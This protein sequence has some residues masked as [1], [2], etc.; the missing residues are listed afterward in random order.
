MHLDLRE[1]RLARAVHRVPIPA[2]RREGENGAEQQQLVALVLWRLDLDGHG[3]FGG[4]V[5]R[6]TRFK[7]VES[8]R[9]YRR[10]SVNCVISLPSSTIVTVFEN[11]TLP[12]N[13]DSSSV[14][15]NRVKA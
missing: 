12:R 8:G 15:M 2:D 1:L 9:V 6:G 11:C 4:D 7:S 14:R 13:G 5:V 10:S 3:Y